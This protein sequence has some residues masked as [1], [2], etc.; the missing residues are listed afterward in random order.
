MIYTN[1]LNPNWGINLKTNYQP[2]H[3]FGPLVSLEKKKDY[4][5]NYITRRLPIS[6]FSS[7]CTT[8]I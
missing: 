7:K 8:L 6:F 3:K 5:I 4:T 2:K 1:L